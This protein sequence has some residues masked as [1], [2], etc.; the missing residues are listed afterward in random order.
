M[1]WKIL[2]FLWISQEWRVDAISSRSPGSTHLLRSLAIWEWR[3]LPLL[4]VLIKQTGLGVQNS[5]CGRL[6]FPDSCIRWGWFFS[7]G[8][9]IKKAFVHQALMI[10]S[11]SKFANQLNYIRVTF[12]GISR[13][14][15]HYQHKVLKNAVFH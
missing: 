1:F 2:K 12:L 14:C 8:C 9:R 15:Y 5:I 3:G 11:G 13:G 4:G 7:Y 6:A 10:C